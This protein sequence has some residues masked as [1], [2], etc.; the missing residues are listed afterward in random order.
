MLVLKVNLSPVSVGDVVPSKARAWK[1]ACVQSINA[2][3]RI[4]IS[5]PANGS[6]KHVPAMMN[7][8]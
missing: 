2:A 7:V 8:E 5:V 6:V 3:G 4:R 1:A